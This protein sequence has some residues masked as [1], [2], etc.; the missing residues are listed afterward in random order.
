M[1]SSSCELFR[2]FFMG[3]LWY[4]ALTRAYRGRYII[5]TKQLPDFIYLQFNVT[6][7]AVGVIPAY[8]SGAHPLCPSHLGGWDGFILQ[9]LVLNWLW[10]LNFLIF[11]FICKCIFLL[12]LLCIWVVSVFSPF[13]VARLSRYGMW[14]MKKCH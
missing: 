12:A 4:Y 1:K 2:S 8:S 14:K 7:A 9:F 11:S 13:S 6:G 3:P 5:E 10:Y